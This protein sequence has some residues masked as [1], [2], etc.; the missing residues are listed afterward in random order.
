MLSTCRRTVWRLR[1]AGTVGVA[2]PRRA[3]HRDVGLALRNAEP[4]HERLRREQ[5]TAVPQDRALARRDR[6]PPQAPRGSVTSASHRDGMRVATPSIARPASSPARAA[7]DR[8]NIGALGHRAKSGR[9]SSR[10]DSARPPPQ[11][12]RCYRA[13]RVPLP[14]RP[15]ASR[16]AAM[17]SVSSSSTVRRPAG[18][19]CTVSAAPA[20]TVRLATSQTVPPP[21]AWA[22]MSG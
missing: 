1:S 19:R 10:A 7:S 12:L 9:A 22:A 8:A 15:Y 20:E 2:P 3:Q 6:T 21:A 5:Q 16:P 14:A 17:T 18:S 4:R 13:P 11:R